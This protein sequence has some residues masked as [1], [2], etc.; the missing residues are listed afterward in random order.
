M[1]MWRTLTCL[2]AALAAAQA[3]AQET[4]VAFTGAR[5]IPITGP[6]VEPGTLVVHRGRI[7]AAG[8]AD[9]PIPQDARRVDA[10]GKVIMPGL[11]DT[12][13]H[14]GGGSG[15]DRS[16]T[17]QPSVRILDSIN[18]FDSGFRRAVAGGLTTLN[19]MPGSGHLLSGQTIY[20]KLRGA[21]DNPDHAADHRPAR[22]IE[23]LVILDGSGVAMGGIKMANGTNP[24]GAPPFSSTRGKH[25][26]LVREQFIKAQE[27][28]D[29]LRAAANDPAKKPDRNI[30]LEA[31]VDA[32]DGK[33]IVHHHTHRADDI[34]TVL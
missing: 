6:E 34:I 21:P 14:I 9:T 8:D 15:A 10:K 1:P 32:L 17:I 4:P 30:G 7:I 31:L 19:I 33:R 23:D 20:V 3:Y 25:A 11:V 5:L 13:S 12:H 18:P 29:K 22:T 28:R 26:A 24:M 16:A 27:Y 2:A